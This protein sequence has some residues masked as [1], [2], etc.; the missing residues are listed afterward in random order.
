MST[1]NRP[2]QRDL[3]GEPGA[4]GPDRVLGD[5]AQDGLAGLQHLLDAGPLGP[6]DD[7]LGLVL[8]V[9]PVED[10][11]LRGADVDEGGLHAR[12]HVLDPADVDVAVDLAD[13]VGRAAHVVLD[14]AAALEHGDLGVLGRDVDGHQVAP[15]RAGPCAPGPGAARASP[16]RARPARS[17]WPA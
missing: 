5:L 12:Q 4:L 6:L 10:G 7:V 14:E 17:R 15:D 3:L 13:V 16:R 11:V 1:T 2:G 8:H 9:A